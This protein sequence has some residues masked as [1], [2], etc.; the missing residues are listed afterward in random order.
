MCIKPF[1]QYIKTEVY[2]M[3]KI[4][5]LKLSTVL[6]QEIMSKFSAEFWTNRAI[7]AIYSVFL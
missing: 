3:A 4:V 7:H 5:F 2:K 6:L 1:R